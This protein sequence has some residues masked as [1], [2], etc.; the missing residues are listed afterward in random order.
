MAKRFEDSVHKDEDVGALFFGVRK[1]TAAALAADGDYIP[2]IVDSS[3]KLHV[4]GDASASKQ[5]TIIG[6]VD[7]IETLLTGIDADTDA[8]KTDIAA[9]EVD[10]AAIE[11]LLTAANVDHAAIEVLLTAANVDHAANE[12][13]LGEIDAVLDTIKIDTEAIETAVEVMDDWDHG[14]TAKV[15]NA[16][17]EP[18]TKVLAAG[19]LTNGNTADIISNTDVSNATGS[20]LYITAITT[21]CITAAA[22]LTIEDT[23]GNDLL[24]VVY[25]ATTVGAA[26][27]YHMSFPTPIKVAADNKGVRVLSTTAGTPVIG[28][29]VTGFIM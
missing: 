1:D 14:D 21:S 22:T 20:R 3:G 29:S 27:T 2:L 9:L 26:P 25:T 4:T 24:Q 18:I 13:K 8:I 6:H 12:V 28:C 17:S 19:A 11:V 23:D 10:L 16:P 5:D 7:G 15:T